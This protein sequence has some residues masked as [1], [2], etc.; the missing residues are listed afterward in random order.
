MVNW[1]KS[2]KH[3]FWEA[4]LITI[5]IFMLGLLVGVAFEK[6][7]I[8]LVEEY[9]SKSEISM[10]DIFVFQKLIEDKEYNCEILIN[11]TIDLADKI[12]EE[13]KLLQIYE[14]SNILTE[15]MI[16]THKKYD[17]L[18][19]F[20]WLNS[21]KIDKEC[22]NEFTPLV[23]LYE[24][25]TKEISIKAEQVVWEKILKE[26]KEKYGRKIV[27]IPIA[28]NNNLSSIDIIISKFKIKEFPAIIIGEDVVIDEL[29]SSEELEEYLNILS[30]Q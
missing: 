21:I 8:N 28:V 3:V 23:Y 6:R 19:S 10:M 12:Y 11:T 7:N 18:R 30:T 26:V 22:Q 13:A 2:P 24:Y 5:V 4:L 9:Y 1:L 27:L 25:N 29:T 17:L 14:D 20:V 15:G 16:L